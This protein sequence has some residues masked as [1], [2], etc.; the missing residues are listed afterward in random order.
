MDD[1]RLTDPFDDNPSRYEAWNY[2]VGQVH[3][4]MIGQLIHD[5]EML[6]KRITE[7]EKAHVAAN[8]AAMREAPPI[9][10]TEKMN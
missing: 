4:H 7:H 2:K 8:Q 1:R 5:L 3:G 10:K 9:P 6:E